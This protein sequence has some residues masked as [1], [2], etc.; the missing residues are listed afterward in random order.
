MQKQYF[1]T[2]KSK[3]SHKKQVMKK[4]ILMFSVF[5][6]ATGM[7]QAQKLSKKF[8]FGFG[9]DGGATSGAISNIYSGAGGLTLRAAYRVGP[10]F[11][12]L[13]SGGLAYI[14]KSIN[15]AT[16]SVGLQ[17]PVKAG[18][19]FIFLKHLYAMGELGF[20]SFKI[21]NAV[22]G[23]VTSTST[24]GF[25]YAPSIGAQF[26]AFDIGIRYESTSVT[27]GSFNLLGA[28]IGFNF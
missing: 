5:V 16:P 28:R 23:T 1:S 21:Y 26:G 7:V 4:L 8:S 13:T 25:T 2:P 20:S 14:P 19:K 9:F 11:V 3:R 17:I 10:G 12:T 6:L 22:G 24:S 15:G 18:Y 27:G